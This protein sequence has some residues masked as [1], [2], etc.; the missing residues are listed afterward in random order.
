MA[1][2]YEDVT[3]DYGISRRMSRSRDGTK[4]FGSIKMIDDNGK[5]QAMWCCL[6]IDA[7]RP[8]SEIEKAA[9]G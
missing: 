4:W 5:E 9:A 2:L 1:K 8:V 7:A 6:P 3:D